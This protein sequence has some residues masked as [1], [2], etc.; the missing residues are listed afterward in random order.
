[1]KVMLGLQ[2]VSEDGFAVVYRR[3]QVELRIQ[4]VATVIPQPYTQLGWS[5]SSIHVIVE[6]LGNRGILFEKYSA[7]TVPQSK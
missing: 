4:I 2:F 3:Q 5:V 7:L 1:M 6:E